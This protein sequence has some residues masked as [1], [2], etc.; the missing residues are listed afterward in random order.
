[1]ALLT[2]LSV[3]NGFQLDFIEDILEISSFHLRLTPELNPGTE[4]ASDPSLPAPP[5][6][7]L[8]NLLTAN[9]EVLSVLPFR[10]IQT[11]IRGD[12]GNW[13][14]CLI[15][16]LPENTA[17]LDPGFV[18]QL[19]LAQGSLNLSAPDSLIIGREMAYRL[20]VRVGD[21]LGLVAMAGENFALLSPSTRDFT[22][23][24]IFHSGYYEFDYSLA[25]VSFA[26]AG[27]LRD[28]QK[29]TY[30]VKLRDR[31]RDRQFLTALDK[32]GENYARLSGE[33][34]RLKAVSWREYNRA[35]FGALKM[36]KNAMMIL[37]GLIFLVVGMNIYH[38]QKRNV[39]ERQEEIGIFRA[40]GGSPEKTRRIFLLEGALIG[41]F[42]A[43][44]GTLLG[45]LISRNIQEIFT[46]VENLVNLGIGGYF[47][48]LGQAGGETLKEAPGFFLFPAIPVRIIFREAVMIHLFAFLSS[49]LA[50]YFA[51]LRVTEINPSRVLRYE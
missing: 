35:F 46:L 29:L 32:L 33:D 40:L 50:A 34:V 12:K 42:G 21:K 16:A 23:T 28:S 43:S 17:A 37:V 47:S 25:L 2:V 6:P 9:R 24:G 5:D 45:M 19:G 44:L 11:L 30:G 36:E 8:I 18:R 13:T 15:R 3:M 7:E 49:L 10:D 39:L 51:S 27:V 22:V 1:M 41:I 31:Y 14:P 4:E 48:L 26:G 20:G 38:S